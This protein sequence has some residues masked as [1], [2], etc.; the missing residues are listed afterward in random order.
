MISEYGAWGVF[1]AT[2]FEEIIVPIPSP[3]IPLAA[4]FFLLPSYHSFTQI[5]FE[6]IFVIG[7][8]VAIGIS[9]GSIAIYALG[10]FG[11]KP[12]IE[13]TKRWTGINWQDIEKT[14]ARLTH[15][16]GDEITLFVL[17]VLPFA[18]SVT[19]SGFC[20]VIRYPV[21]KFLVITF[22]GTFFRALI[23]GIIGW[24][25]GELYVTYAG[26]ISRF[27]KHIFLGVIILLLLGTG[28]YYIS[29]KIKVRNNKQ[30][31]SDVPK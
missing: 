27:E 10:F 31:S 28:A 3:M 7:I 25:V 14:E 16:A 12:I 20:G 29:K 8:P 11:G 2:I 19:I 21:K 24:K 15:S 9:I 5:I 6:G 4:G 13:K 22:L 23:L 18:P 26:I 17:R 1:L 30:E